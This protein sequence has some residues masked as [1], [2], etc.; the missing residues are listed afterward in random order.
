[1]DVSDSARK[2][3]DFDSLILLYQESNGWT[4]RT[5]LFTSIRLGCREE[6]GI[7]VFGIQARN[8]HRESSP[9]LRLSCIFGKTRDSTWNIEKTISPCKSWV[10]CITYRYPTQNGEHTMANQNLPIPA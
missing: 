6:Y 7:A 2:H 4:S 10:I 5:G 8:S 1:M 9:N 3:P